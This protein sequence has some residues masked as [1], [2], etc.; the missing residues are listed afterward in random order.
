MKKYTYNRL[1][2]KQREFI[3]SNKD[4]MDPHEL[5]KILEI[6]AETVKTFIKK[7][8]RTKSIPDIKPSRKRRLIEDDML[9]NIMDYIHSRE[10]L[11]ENLTWESIINEFGLNVS[12]KTLSY[13]VNKRGG[14]KRFD[15]Y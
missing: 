13:Y 15:N 12:I 11:Q 6:K 9:D 10:N 2:E 3:A 1:S 14:K 7:Y 8:E 4:F 5:A